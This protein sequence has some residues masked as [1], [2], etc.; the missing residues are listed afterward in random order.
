MENCLIPTASTVTRPIGATGHTVKSLLRGLRFIFGSRSLISRGVRTLLHNFGA[1][2]A[3][4]SL[5][6]NK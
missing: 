6:K 4:R 1:I 2:F 5:E 3:C